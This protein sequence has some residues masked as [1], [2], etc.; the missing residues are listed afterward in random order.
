MATEQGII[1][2][3]VAAV[4]LLLVAV[5]VLA[6]Y[7]LGSRGRGRR[8]GKG[9]L[10]PL[11]PAT[12]TGT[13]TAPV[14]LPDTISPA[15]QDLR[16]ELRGA[17][18]DVQQKVLDLQTRAAA[19]TAAEQAR[20]G[21]EDRAWGAIQ[22]VETLLSGI[23][24]ASTS[25]QQTLQEQVSG[26]LRELGAI[27]MLQAEER[28]RWTEEDR[29]FTS[30]QQ[31]ANVM[32]GSARKGA[33][34]ERLVREALSGLPPQWLITNHRVAGRPVEFAIHLPD[35]HI[36]PVDSK[37]VAQA[38]LDALAQE[39]DPDRRRQLEK[40]V[41]DKVAAK[42][43]EVRQYIDD[44]APGFAIAA[45]PDAAY[46]VCGAALSRAYHEQHVLVVPYSLLLPFVLMVYEQHRHTGVDWESERLAR[47]LS[48]AHGHVQR[49]QHELNGRLGNAL[50]Q[51]KNGHEELAA[52]LAEAARALGQMRA[53]TAEE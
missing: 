8:V 51:L 53:S 26:A 22:R 37:V 28:Q 27:K 23:G 34:G 47:L 7:L 36:L 35:G 42:A 24:Q 33:A 38:E 43:A 15:I 52:A 13:T 11:P 16:A 45:V 32:L 20:R 29:A 1:V 44:R 12:T 5:L 6:A 46:A 21:A 14:V 48:A 49:A 19:E 31:L 30:L 10:V 39:Q 2:A 3:L 50:T 17:L 41:Q 9:D 25:I 18:A 4:A 40:V